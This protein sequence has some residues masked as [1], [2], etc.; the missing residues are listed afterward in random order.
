MRAAAVWC[1]IVA[2]SLLPASAPAQQPPAH[3]PA[4]S[5]QTPSSAG[6]AAQSA[7]P[8]GPVSAYLELPVREIRFSGVAEREKDH[9]RQLLPQKVGQPLN[10]DSIR[11]SVKVLYDSG[12]FADI[13]VRLRKP[14]TTR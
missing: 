5:Q 13:Q 11:D 1:V 14:P 2:V 8:L 9:L 12:L 6:P 4:L 3:G 10:R 7:S